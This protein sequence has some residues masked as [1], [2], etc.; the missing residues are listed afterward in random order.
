MVSMAQDLNAQDEQSVRVLY[1]D[2]EV[3]ETYIRQ[4]FGHAWGKLLHQKQVVEVNNV[5]Q[6]TKPENIL[7]IAPGPARLATELKGVRRGV[8]LDNSAAMLVLAKRRLKEAGLE[9]CWEVEQGN[10]FDLGNFQRQFSFLFTF[11]FLRHF[12]L[13]ERSRLYSSIG[14]CLRPGGLLMFDVVN[15]T[16][17]DQLDTKY[18]RKTGELEVYDET[19]TPNTLRQEMKEYGFRVLRLTPVLKHFPL[20]TWTSFRLDHRLSALSSVLVRSI[21]HIPSRQPLE[22]IALCQRID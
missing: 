11:R 2:V 20:Q 5:I 6:A 14:A 7:E 15:K 19:Y 10:A 21:E 1:E 4:R 8:M 18:P 16:L 13:D 22:W 3:A 17:R 9:H 12:C